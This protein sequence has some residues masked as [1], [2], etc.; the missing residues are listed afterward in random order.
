MLLGY[1]LFQALLLRLLPWIVRQPFAP[2]CW[3]FTFDLSAAAIV[4]PWAPSSR[5][6][7]AGRRNPA[8]GGSALIE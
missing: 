8:T 6:A 7:C 1:G 5:S 2:S 3:A 4:P